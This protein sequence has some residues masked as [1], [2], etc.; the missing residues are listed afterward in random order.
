MSKR[1]L[2][3]S[4]GSLNSFFMDGVR[5]G[6]LAHIYGPYQAGKTLLILQ[7]LYEWVSKGFGNALI[8]DTELTIQNNFNGRWLERF[9]K[10]FGK[11][12][13]MT[14][15]EERKY[16]VKGGKKL[17]ERDVANVVREV[18]ADLNIDVERRVIINIIEQL[19]PEKELYP[20][21][22]VDKLGNLFVYEVKNLEDIYRLLGMEFRAE[23]GKDKKK[24]D[25]DVVKKI[26]LYS[27]PLARFIENYH[28]KFISLDSLGGLMKI[29][30]NKIQ[31]FPARASALNILLHGISRLANE[32][33]A[34]VFVANHESRAPTG[35]FY[36]FYGGSAVG[37]GFKYTL[38]LKKVKE[39]IRELIG[40]RAPHIPEKAFHATLYIKEGG[41]YEAPKNDDKTR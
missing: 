28:V 29:F 20:A 26:D 30:V 36:S 21:D 23:G 33:D 32:F 11:R 34:V 22:E 38:Y 3:E 2:I 25:I 8:L 1:Y 5:V 41:F 9:T 18:L 15:V 40:Y 13:K 39:S 19:L 31:D 16:Q 6:T 35:N 27:S 14:G 10:R 7:I 4:I 37:Y 17:F 12:I 24:I